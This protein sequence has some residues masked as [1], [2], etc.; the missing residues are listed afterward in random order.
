MW[1]VCS[2]SSSHTIEP[3]ASRSHVTFRCANSYDAHD[4]ECQREHQAHDHPDPH[5]AEI[6][7]LAGA[8]RQ[9]IGNQARR[10]G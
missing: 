7:A 2:P 1:V 4:V 9:F 10:A 6:D 5:A 3:Y 8:P